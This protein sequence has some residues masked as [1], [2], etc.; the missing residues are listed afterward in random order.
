MSGRSRGRLVEM[1][2][3]ISLFV[4]PLSWFQTKIARPKVQF[5]LYYIH[6]EI[7]QFNWI[8]TRTARMWLVP[9][10][11]EPVAGLWKSETRNTFTFHFESMSMSRQCNMIAI[12]DWLFCFTVLLSLTGKK[13]RFRAKNI[14]ICE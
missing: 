9:L 10:Y 11:I 2:S 12:C 8:N 5:P 6:F 3:Y 1:N 7:P 4:K 13:M 14:A